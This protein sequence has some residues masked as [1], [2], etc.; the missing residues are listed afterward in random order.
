MGCSPW[1]LKELDSAEPLSMLHTRSSPWI[2]P[3]EV[4]WSQSLT[5]TRL[6]QRWQMACLE[7]WAAKCCIQELCCPWSSLLH[8]RP[9]P[10]DEPLYPS[11]FRILYFHNIALTPAS[12]N[13][14][15]LCH[16]AT[17]IFTSWWPG[18]SWPGHTTGGHGRRWEHLSM[19]TE[20]CDHLLVA[21]GNVCLFWCLGSW[22]KVSRRRGGYGAG[23]PCDDQ[24]AIL[25]S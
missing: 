3:P 10:N 2:S 1:G 23:H 17:A 22:E 19:C 7:N 13:L 20:C 11:K 6:T 14:S 9:S 8:L 15:L 4:C 12:S 16:P 25:S 21:K 24:I 18:N 5:P